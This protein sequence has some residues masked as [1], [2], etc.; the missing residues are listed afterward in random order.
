MKKSENIKE[1]TKTACRILCKLINLHLWKQ[2]NY[3]INC[4]QQKSFTIPQNMISQ[5]DSRILILAKILQK[6]IPY[7]ITASR[8]FSIWKY[9]SQKY[10]KIVNKFE[11]AFTKVFLPF[12]IVKCYIFNR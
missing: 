5:N 10:Q 8:A 6:L 3:A 2:V 1:S 11:K 4:I 9:N 7:K 12:S